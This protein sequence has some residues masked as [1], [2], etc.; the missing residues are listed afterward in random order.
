[1][2]NNWSQNSNQTAPRGESAIFRP[3]LS[4]NFL[5]PARRSERVDVARMNT[6][7][8]RKTIRPKLTTLRAQLK[9]LS[10]CIQ[11]T[12]QLEQTH[13]Q[14]YNDAQVSR[15]KI[16]CLCLLSRGA[17]YN[18][19]LMTTWRKFCNENMNNYLRSF[20]MLL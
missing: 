14:K 19:Y 9:N 20:K 17:N 12:I 18:F 1:M 7:A 5:R 6:V 13:T 8:R 2:T 4:M 16:I 3:G 10:S 11:M 15:T